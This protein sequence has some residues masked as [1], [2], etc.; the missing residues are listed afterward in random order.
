MVVIPAA[1]FF[2]SSK[3]FVSNI[4]I[5]SVFEIGTWTLYSTRIVIRKSSRGET[6]LV[7]AIWYF[8]W[9]YKPRYEAECL[10]EVWSNYTGYRMSFNVDIWPFV[11]LK[12]NNLSSVI[13]ES[14]VYWSLYDL[15]YKSAIVLLFESF[16]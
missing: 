13:N 7:N 2:G 16:R 3:N 8:E 10:R 6:Q 11:I 15:L 14:K 4:Y 12:T 1:R 5:C 9:A